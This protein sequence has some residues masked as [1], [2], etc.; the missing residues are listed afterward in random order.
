MVVRPAETGIC[1]VLAWKRSFRLDSQ[2]REHD[3]LSV[4]RD[5][6]TFLHR[7]DEE[8][9][10]DGHDGQLAPLHLQ[11]YA[12]YDVSKVSL[13][14]GESALDQVALAVCLV[15]AARML[16]VPLEHARPCGESVSGAVLLWQQAG[17]ASQR[18]R[19]L[20]VFG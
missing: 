13:D 17:H 14:G 6:G 20:A 3:P 4:S 16:L 5:G 15:E 9:A 7:L 11:R 12:A 8:V 19:Q 10:A 2:V 1:T 18:Y